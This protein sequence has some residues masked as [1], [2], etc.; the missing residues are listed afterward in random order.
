MAGPFLRL[1]V[2]ELFLRRPEQ[3][4]LT[5]EPQ[6][7]RNACRPECSG[8]P[9]STT[10]FLTGARETSRV[11]ITMKEKFLFQQLLGGGGAHL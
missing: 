11:V 10:D 5:P 3:H 1:Q 2:Y 7:Q 4:L 9:V 8:E 6:E